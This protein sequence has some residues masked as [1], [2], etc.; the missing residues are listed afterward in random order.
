M[1]TSCLVKS[2]SHFEICIIKKAKNLKKRSITE[3]M[4]SSAD[5]ILE[6]A[7]IITCDSI[8]PLAQSVAIKND[9][10]LRVGSNRDIK[11]FKHKHTLIIDCQGKTLVPGFIDAHCHIY[12]LINRLFSLDLSPKSV[13][14]IQDIQHFIRQKIRFSEPGRWIIGSAYDEFYLAEKRHPT[15]KDL[16]DISPDNPVVLFHRSS[17]ACVLNSLALSLVGI[18]Y[19]TEEPPGGVIER[20]LETGA[21][22]GIL[23]E[24]SAFLSDKIKSP[25]SEKEIDWAV[26]QANEIYLSN[27]IT[28]LGEASVSNGSSQWQF[29][30][31]LKNKNLLKSRIYMMLGSDSIRNFSEAGLKTGSG[32]SYLRLGSVKIVLS[33][34]TGRI[35]PSQQELTYL[36]NE[37]SKNEFQVAIHGVERTTIEAAITALEN[38]NKKLPHANYRNR[39][40]HCSE[41]PQDLR[42]RLA[43]IQAMVVSQPPFLYYNGERYLSQVSPESQ[44][45]L[46]PFKSLLSNGILVAA[47]SDSP[48][49]SNNPL[50]GIYSAV[51]RKA[52][53]GKSVLVNESVTIKQALEM[54]TLYGAY[55]SSEEKSKGSLSPGKMADVVM[56]NTNP[57]EST[58]EQIKDIKVERTIIGGKVVWEQP[59]SKQDTI[60]TN[61]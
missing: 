2:L 51:T 46:Y 57:L 16:D 19:E 56:L 18:N 50:I 15:R 14:S 33:E 39:I 22:N 41:C 20:D 32:D 25:I 35:L 52:E 30:Q 45:W 9:L 17:H 49:V 5:L 13:K 53:S 4:S 8:M 34:A 37:A 60:L 6:N 36:V 31:Q 43:K 29:F 54:Y 47:S 58:T 24:L 11:S 23:Y 48:I 21:P 28:S 12:S 40:E 27:G 59:N 7:N 1:N 42:F 61:N 10:I 55:A 26:A 38:A 44:Q 3:K